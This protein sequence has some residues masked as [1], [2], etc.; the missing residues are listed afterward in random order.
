[1]GFPVERAKALVADFAGCVPYFF[2][3]F[4]LTGVGF[5]VTTSRLLIENYA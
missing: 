1:M 3:A 4:Y 5:S 2:R